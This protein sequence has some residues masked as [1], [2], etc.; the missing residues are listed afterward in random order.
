MIALA[1][2]LT[3]AWTA[4][5]LLVPLPFPEQGTV[6]AIVAW[7]IFVTAIVLNELVRPTWSSRLIYLAAFL[8][9]LAWWSTIRPSS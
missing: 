7:A 6:V 4:P 3:G 8:A 1:I 9:V 2:L 5:R